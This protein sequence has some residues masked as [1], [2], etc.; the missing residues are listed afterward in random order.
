MS[1][2]TIK[3]SISAAAFGSTMFATK[4]FAQTSQLENSVNSVQKGANVGGT[5]LTEYISLII[6]ILLGIIGVVAVIMLIIG[7]FRYV[8]SAGNEKATSGAKDTILF[9]IIGIVVAVLAF[10]IVNFVIGGLGQ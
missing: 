1:I 10:A 3:K 4:V 7:G 9:A 5:T 6:N 8:L 2:K